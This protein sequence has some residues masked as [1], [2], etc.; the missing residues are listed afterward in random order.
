MRSVTP[1]EMKSWKPTPG[2]LWSLSHVPLLFADFALH[3][4]IMI[5]RSCEHTHKEKS[6]LKQYAKYIYDT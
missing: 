4:F 2:F 5:N 6:C 3:P 1:M